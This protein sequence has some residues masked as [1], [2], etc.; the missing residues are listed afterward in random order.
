[1]ECKEEQNPVSVTE[2]EKINKA[3]FAHE[4]TQ[5]DKRSTSGQSCPSSSSKDSRHEI[6][7]FNASANEDRL[8]KRK[9]DPQIYEVNEQAKFIVCLT[10]MLPKFIATIP[11]CFA[12]TQDKRKLDTWLIK[13]EN[14]LRSIQVKSDRLKISIATTLFDGY[15]ADWWYNRTKHVEE[16]HEL[17]VL[18]WENFLNIMEQ[19]FVPTET[20]FPIQDKLA[21]LK[22]TGSVPSYIA[23]FL[24]LAIHLENSSESEKV[25]RFIDGLKPTPSFYISSKRP[26]S[27]LE[28]I[29]LAEKWAYSS[30]EEGEI[31]THKRRKI[32][33]RTPSPIKT[34]RQLP[35]PSNNRVEAHNHPN[36]SNISKRLT[37]A[38]MTEYR[39]RGL[40]FNCSGHG[41]T[42]FQCTQRFLWHER[43]LQHPRS[44]PPMR[45]FHSIPSPLVF[46]RFP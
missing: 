29:N 17:P 34:D 3:S 41:H 4:V 26:T 44:I 39:K 1:M 45:G 35:Y 15:A 11:P 25:S 16:G 12:G 21:V 2:E 28:A 27:M 30:V 19:T 38:E 33:T 5:H 46:R 37:D 13:V 31:I 42:F 20:R 32:V 36:R 43:M 7:D 22:Q 23:K 18:S 40:C 14:Y 10:N 24:S 9:G 6:F 8:K